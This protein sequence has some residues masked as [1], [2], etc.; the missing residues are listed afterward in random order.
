MLSVGIWPQLEF[1]SETGEHHLVSNC[2]GLDMAF[3]EKGKLLK[4][5]ETAQKRCAQLPHLSAAV[6]TD[7]FER[8]RN[9]IEAQA[10]GSHP[11]K[12][13]VIFFF[14]KRGDLPELQTFD[15][16]LAHLKQG[17]RKREFRHLLQ[18][19]LEEDGYRQAM[20]A[21]F[22]VE[23][24]AELLSVGEAISVNLY[25]KSPATQKKPDA[26]IVLAQKTVYI[27]ITL[28]SQAEYQ[29][30]IEDIREK[31]AYEQV[32]L[33]ESEMEE[34]GI[35]SVQGGRNHGVGFPYEDALRVIGKLDAKRDQLVPGAPNII[36]LGLSDLNPGI[37]SV[38]W[39]TQ[40]FFSGSPNMAQAELDRFT[41]LLINKSASMRAE[42]V[43]N[44]WGKIQTLKRLIGHFKAEPQLTGVLTFQRKGN[45][46]S[47][48]KVF[49]NPS[50][51]SLNG[52][53]ESDWKDVLELFGLPLVGDHA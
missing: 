1:I 49:R 9:C 7:F 26:C 5:L 35:R 51:C 42:K 34:L 38:E 22:E 37:R 21:I 31:S 18:R 48:K 41:A 40:D 43:R 13:P 4:D 30:K 15:D 32:I 19:L 10:E 20:G 3:N 2:Y 33:D 27:E 24:L 8:I 23:V 25:P 44:I 29:E 17:R 14:L 6:P 52:L 50:P 12:L 47:P 46:F 36:C 28:L 39:A 11:F 45:G 53:T 16:F